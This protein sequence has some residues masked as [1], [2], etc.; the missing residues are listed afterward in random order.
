MLLTLLLGIGII[1]TNVF[2]ESLA[3]G[4]VLVYLVRR[5][6]RH[7]AGTSFLHDSVT[8][9]ATLLLKL[10]GH[11]LQISIWALVFVLLGEFQGFSTALY[12]STVNFT[13]LG[14]GDIVLSEHWRLLGALE[15]GVGVMMFGV[16]TALFFAVLGRFFGPRLQKL[17]DA[18][19]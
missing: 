16:S 13:T 12:H 14:Y 5:L 18:H 6:S 7:P 17:Q 1:V 3:V 9:S 11:L 10:A 15:A 19:R 2:V 8:L 4:L